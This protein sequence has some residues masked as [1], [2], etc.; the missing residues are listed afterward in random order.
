MD[1]RCAFAPKVD[2]V[3]DSIGEQVSI[4]RKYEIHMNAIRK[5]GYPMIAEK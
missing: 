5:I 1:A 3:F 4:K 2:V